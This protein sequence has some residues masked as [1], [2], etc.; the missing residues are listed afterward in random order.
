MNLFDLHCDTALSLYTKNESLGHGNCHISLDRAVG[1][2]HYAQIMA[3]WSAHTLDNGAAWKQFHHA[4]DEL[5]RQVDGERERTVLCRTADELAAAWTAGKSA[6]ILAVEDARLLDGEIDRLPVLAARGVRFL[7]LTWSGDTC[8]GGS[9]NSTCGLTEFGRAVVA[10]CFKL[11]IIPD[12]SH[13]SDATADETIA[14]AR[15]ADKAVVATHSNAR[16]VCAHKR[17]LT[18]AQFTAIRDLGG[19]VGISLCPEHLSAAAPRNIDTVLRHI[20]H[21]LSLGGEKTICLG[22]D[23]DGTNLPDGFHGIEDMEKIADALAARNYPQTL[24][25][26]ITFGNALRFAEQN[27]KA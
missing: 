23:L 13:A 5:L 10:Q 1:Y 11:G 21:Y 7:T 22:A 19:I 3:I 25:E 15:A 4:A 12:V 9:H 2:P 18:D 17:N 24:I 20:E 14:M 8:I 16:A 27:L 26:N 6:L